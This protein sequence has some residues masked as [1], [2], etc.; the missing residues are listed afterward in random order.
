M[1]AQIITLVPVTRGYVRQLPAAA[2]TSGYNRAASKERWKRWRAAEVASEFAERELAFLDYLSIARQYGVAEALNYAPSDDPES[3]WP[4]VLR[5]RA[6]RA[7]LMLTPAHDLA[8]L[9]WKRAKLNGRKADWWLTDTTREAV[10][11]QI[12]DDEAWLAAHGRRRR[13]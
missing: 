8:S 6:L 12:A 4:V 1:S 9:K 3:R 5:A 7:Q 13:R 11:A 2:E 10:E